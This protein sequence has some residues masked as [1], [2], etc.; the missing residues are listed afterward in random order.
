MIKFISEKQCTVCAVSRKLF[1]SNI[2]D[3]EHFIGCET[4]DEKY[5]GDYLTMILLKNDCYSNA[6]TYEITDRKYFN[7]IKEAAETVGT[8]ELGFELL[9][10]NGFSTRMHRMYEPVTEYRAV[11][12]EL[13]EQPYPIFTDPPVTERAEKSI[14]EFEVLKETQEYLSRMRC[15]QKLSEEDERDLAIRAI[16][17]DIE[18]K[19]RI[20]ENYLRTA[21]EIAAHYVNEGSSFVEL[22]D[23]GNRA[24]EHAINTLD[25]ISISEIPDYIHWEIRREIMRQSSVSYGFGVSPGHS[26]DR[27]RKVEQ[28]YK[29]MLREN[30][31][32]PTDEELAEESSCSLDIVND[33]LDFMDEKSE[34]YIDFLNNL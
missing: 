2:R 8:K 1:Y 14:A 7:S 18:A 22:V 16:S 31:H 29:R 13:E 21:Y 26:I 27:M 33:Y 28:T 6:V 32:E 23:V 11:V 4:P 24:L 15:T 20:M 5:K 30:D 34:E 12:F 9:S 3:C 25:S 19:K 10:P 17:G